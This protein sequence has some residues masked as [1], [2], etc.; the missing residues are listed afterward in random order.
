MRHAL[1]MMAASNSR[2]PAILWIATRLPMSTHEDLAFFRAVSLLACLTGDGGGSYV[3]DSA[4][5]HHLSPLSVVHREINEVLPYMDRAQPLQA[6]G[7]GTVFGTRATVA[8]SRPASVLL[9]RK[10]TRIFCVR[11]WP[12]AFAGRLWFD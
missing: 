7:G 11:A 12:V 1:A 10:V 3:K 2:R 8:W 6:R 9:S 5:V 4:G